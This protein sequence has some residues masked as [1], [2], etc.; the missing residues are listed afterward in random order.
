M[1]STT[2]Q[3]SHDAIESVQLH[4]RDDESGLEEILTPAN[5]QP[6]MRPVSR[7]KQTSILLCAFLD[8][9][10]TIGLNQAYGVFL[11]YYLTDGSSPRDPFLSKEEVSSKAMLAFVGTL[12][13]GLTWGG[14][15]GVNPLMA[16]SKDPRWIT[17]A[18]VVLIGLGYILASFCHK[19]PTRIFPGPV[20]R[21]DCR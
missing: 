21:H 6:A 20:T 2:V 7:K 1:S 4:S 8:V 10:V 3:T 16:R 12:G 17:G 9:F 13:A 15:I 11:N 19:V 5:A 18:G 14:S